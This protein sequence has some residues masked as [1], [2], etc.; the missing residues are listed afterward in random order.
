MLLD[1]SKNQ[2]GQKSPVSTPN[3]HLAH[4]ELM[5]GRVTA[6]VFKESKLTAQDPQIYHRMVRLSRN[7]F[8][9]P[10]PED[11]KDLVYKDIQDIPRICANIQDDWHSDFAATSLNRLTAHTLSRALRK[12]LEARLRGERTYR[13]VDV[14]L[15]G[16]EVSLWLAEQFASDLQKAFPQLSTLAMSSNKLLGLFGQDVAVPAF[17]FPYSPQVYDLHDTI[18]IIVSHSGGTFA[19]LS[20]CNLLQ[21]STRE[22]FAVT[23]EWDTQMGKQLRAMDNV[24]GIEQLCCSRIFSTEVG[25][26]PAEPCSVRT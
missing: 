12:L 4:H 10:L 24:D 8:V 6:V 7:K 13:E 14:L 11:S 3:R 23:S 18:V 15:T 26:R 22:I 17:G 5:N 25:L 21:S 9:K 2:W 1:Y 16:C 20:C 19:P